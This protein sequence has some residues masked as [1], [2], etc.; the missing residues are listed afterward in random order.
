MSFKKSN[1]WTT[2]PSPVLVTPGRRTGNRLDRGTTRR[3]GYPR[4]PRALVGIPTYLSDGVQSFGT[5][6]TPTPRLP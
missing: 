5:S 3:L 1:T 4:S 2:S 6:R